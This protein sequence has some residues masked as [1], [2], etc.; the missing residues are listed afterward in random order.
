[1]K[2]HT[3]QRYILDAFVQLAKITKSATALSLS[4]LIAESVLAAGDTMYAEYYSCI[5]MRLSSSCVSSDDY[6]ITNIKSCVKQ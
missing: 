5:Y 4:L 2:T 1:M 6:R 3:A